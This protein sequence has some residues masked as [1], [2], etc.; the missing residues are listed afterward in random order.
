MKSGRCLMMAMLLIVQTMAQAV[1]AIQESDPP[2][3]GVEAEAP[4][5]RRL[6]VKHHYHDKSEI[7]GGVIICGLVAAAFAVVFFYIRV[8]R[9]TGSDVP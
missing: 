3:A 7:G 4:V 2:R 6:L 5:S 8:T 9:E 1:E